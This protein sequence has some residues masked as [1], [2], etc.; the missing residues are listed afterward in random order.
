MLH[1]LNS[2]SFILPNVLQK[3]GLY[4]T[5]K[6]TKVLVLWNVLW[7]YNMDYNGQTPHC[8]KSLICT[9]KTPTTEVELYSGDRTPTVGSDLEDKV[10]DDI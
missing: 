10:E 4:N 8:T 9:V 6:N 2:K 1:W 3:L 5:N 7:Q